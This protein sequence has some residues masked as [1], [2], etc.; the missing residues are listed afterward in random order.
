MPDILY[1]PS[2]PQ[3][4]GEILDSTFRIFS[5]TLVKCLPF[6]FAAVI[7]GQLPTL[8]SFA[9]G[10]PLL[11]AALR[12]SRDPL[13]W[14]LE[15]VAIF[16]TLTLTNAVL[17]RQYAL[18]TGHPAATGEELATGARRV[19]GML[20]IAVLL[21]LA[22]VATLIPVMAI[23]W[24]PLGVLAGGGGGFGGVF[25]ATLV[26]VLMLLCASWVVVR[27]ICSGALYLLTDRGPVASMSYS[28]E[29]TSGNFWRLTLIY[30]VGIV[31]VIVFYVLSGVVGAVGSALLAR[32]DV[33][34]VTAV[35]AA[36]MALLGALMGPFYSA[37]ALA[38]LGDLSVRKEGADLA[39][40]I[41][42]PAA[43]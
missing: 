11:Q 32:G 14:I 30:G 12:G 31:L 5:A 18:A 28:W 1:P 39:V 38:V 33:A 42:A 16:G 13:W 25:G 19:P 20:L 8:Y 24:F 6:A 35:T 29:L 4:V 34:V 10:R 27:W 23:V 43:R 40:R 41:A 17:L 15:L 36:V 9:T 37:L 7:L 3:S 21:G 22:V 26:L 2:R